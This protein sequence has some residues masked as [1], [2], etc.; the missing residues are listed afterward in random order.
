MY[1][2]FLVEEKAVQIPPCPLNSAC[3]LN[4]FSA[5][6]FNLACSIHRETIEYDS[7]VPP[8]LK[9]GLDNM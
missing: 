9:S 1:S 4:Y 7:P 3:L 2:E 6:S 8:A 5:R